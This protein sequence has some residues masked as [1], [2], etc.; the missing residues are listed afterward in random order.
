M[1][2]HW[3]IDRCEWHLLWRSCHK[4]REALN[5]E[6]KERQATGTVEIDGAH[7]VGYVKPSNYVENRQDRRLARNQT[8]KR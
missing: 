6:T 4:L 5:A 7:F 1:P 2:E 3:R 8:G